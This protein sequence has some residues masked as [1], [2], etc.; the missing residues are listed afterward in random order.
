MTQVRV[1]V[2]LEKI[3]P[4]CGSI[5]VVAAFATATGTKELQRNF[6]IVAV[7]HPNIKKNVFEVFLPRSFE[8]G[9]SIAKLLNQFDD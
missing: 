9:G 8:I 2:Q 6:L 7:V 3:F 4:V 1:S 5:V